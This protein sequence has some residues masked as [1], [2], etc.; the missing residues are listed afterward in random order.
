MATLREE[1][2]YYR[3]A[4][5][6]GLI[7]AEMVVAWA[8]RTIAAL[9]EPPIQVV[10]VALSGGRRE[11]E[12]MDLLKLVPGGGDLTAVAHQV[13]ALFGQRFRSGEFEL[14]AAVEKLSAYAAWATISED[15]QVRASNFDDFL[16]G[17]KHGQYC[18]VESLRREIIDF[19]CK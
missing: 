12:I 14:E 10:D 2:E 19:A 4:L 3:I 8:D 1:A 6:M 5:A 7:D 16:Y 13:L 11:F 18:T 9:P 15:E 17:V